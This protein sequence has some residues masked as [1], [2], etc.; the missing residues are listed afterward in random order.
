VLALS[1]APAAQA[2]APARGQYHLNAP[3][4]GG[5]AGAQPGQQVS[6]DDGG[7]SSTLWIVVA[8]A[9]VAAA[10]TAIL[11]ARGRNEPPAPR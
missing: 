9:V 6:T 10:G 11:Y 7:S 3:S 8:V 4:A 1:L 2:T 5:D